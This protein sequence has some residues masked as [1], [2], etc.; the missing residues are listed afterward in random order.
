YE[1]VERIGGGAMGSVYRAKR[2]KL[3][4]PV[5]IKVMHHGLPEGMKAR[6]RFEREAKILARIDDPHCVSIIDYG[7]HAQ[8]PFVVVEL[9]RGRSLF[10]MLAEH[11]RLERERAGELMLQVLSGLAHAHEQGIVHR[12]IKPANLMIT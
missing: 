11:T 8:K 6:K 2:L 10:E 5:A 4:R 9:G 12:D 3:D 1:I 7:M